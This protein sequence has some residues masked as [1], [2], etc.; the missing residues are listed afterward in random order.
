[1]NSANSTRKEN[2]YTVQKGDSLYQIA[3]K[4]NTSVRQIIEWNHLTNTLLTV[5]QVLIIAKEEEKLEHIGSDICPDDTKDVE[6]KQPI[7]DTYT[8]KE[9]ENLYMIAQ[10]FQTTVA[11][12][13]Y[14]NHLK[15]HLLS[16][17]QQIKVPHTGKNFTIYSVKPNDTLYQ[18]ASN[19]N[20]TPKQLLD[21]NQLTSPTLTIG[22]ELKIPTLEREE[23]VE[24]IL[25]TVKKEDSLFS[26]SQKFGT[27]VG[28]IKKLNNLINNLLF[29]GQ[30][31]KIPK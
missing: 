1:M 9:N 17:G 25:Y 4:F 13:K 22:Q 7:Y 29:I 19:Y 30:E 21:F 27:T 18:I 6:M 2:T 28:E 8:V 16:I 11:H 15:N 3:K 12:L 10:K 26:I 20:V 5:G 31:L 24:V 14:I 23:E